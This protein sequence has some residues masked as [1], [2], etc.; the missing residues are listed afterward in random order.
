MSRSL[1]AECGEAARGGPNGVDKRRRL[2]PGRDDTDEN[3]HSTEDI[4]KKSL[5]ACSVLIV[6][7]GVFSLPPRSSG[8]QQQERE[9]QPTRYRLVDLG[10]L[11]GP[12]SYQPFGYAGS[13]S[14]L[15]EASLSSGGTFAGWADTATPDPYA[16]CFFD[17]F[18]DH[19]FQWKDGVRTDL[20]ALPGAPGLSSAVTSISPNGIISGFS[21]TSEID[22]LFDL[23]A[24]HGVVWQNGYIIDLKTFEGGFESW[25]N[26]VNSRG[27][28]VGFAS[29][30][31]GDANSLQGL[32]TQTRAFLWQ[33]GMMKDLGT[34]GGNDAE[35]LFIND[36]GQ[37]AGQS[38]T[39][40]AIPPPNLHCSD[41]PLTLHAFLWEM[42]RMVDLGTLGG[43]C[44]FVSALNE[45]GQVAG[46]STI[47]GDGESHPFIWE[48]EKIKDLGAL[49]GTFGYASWLNGRGM[50]VG[51]AT[52]EGDKVLLAYRWEDGAMTNLGTLAG[53]TCSVSDGVNNSGQ[54]VGGSGLFDSAFFSACTD[55]VE[56]AFLWE[57][58]QMID[59][60][61]FVPSG[62]DLTLNEAV[63]INDSGV[64]SGTG[65]LPNG[66]QHAFLLIPCGQDDAGSCREAGD[67]ISAI[68]RK[69]TSI[70]SSATTAIQ[71]NGTRRGMAARFY[72]RPVRASRSAAV[73]ST[74]TTTT[75]PTPTNLTSFAFSRG[76]DEIV[77]LAWT[78][79]SKDSDSYYLESC[80]GSTCTNF[81]QIAKLGANAT[82]Y[83]QYFQFVHNI[84]LRYRVRAHGPGGYSGYSN[85]RTQTLS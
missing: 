53:D 47:A 9:N 51:A 17:C 55:A 42:G 11:G 77:R 31:I 43:S 82:T 38:Y 37:I 49:G 80:T 50:V 71:P 28:V 78:N 76:F 62:S 84:T 40:N 24:F 59:L 2:P 65:T 7:G 57:N 74:A 21:E 85:I 54:V 67:E 23:L 52:I 36:R 60:N 35:A 46:Q 18:V 41:T 39:I 19:A 12:N 33:D 58:G 68:E 1:S 16:P 70:V 61:R 4:M 15:T 26:A 79:N 8:Q 45:N 56:H 48:R 72:G 25:A 44:A 29:N 81:R 13:G 73:D 69:S 83:T 75:E 66:D 6:L 3:E 64:I 30:A 22:P 34:L 32:V 10:T 14:F 5:L 27:H 63:F 20:G